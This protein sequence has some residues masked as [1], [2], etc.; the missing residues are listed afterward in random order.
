[1]IKR[2]VHSF[3][4]SFMTVKVKEMTG[5]WQ[6]RSVKGWQSISVFSTTVVHLHFSMITIF[7]LFLPFLLHTNSITWMFTK[8]YA[9]VSNMAVSNRHCCL[10]A[11]AQCLAV[12]WMSLCVCQHVFV[13]LSACLSELLCINICN[14]FL[15]LCLSMRQYL[16]PA[17]KEGST[18]PQWPW[19]RSGGQVRLGPSSGTCKQIYF[20]AY[21]FVFGWLGVR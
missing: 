16:E 19:C 2:R 6:E 18:K 8:L 13:C 4:I 14:L 5:T 21:N 11:I 17:Q 12:H 7:V 1:M 20:F 15:S 9:C 3:W 10:S